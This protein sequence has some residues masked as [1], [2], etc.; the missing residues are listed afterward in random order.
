MLPQW[1]RIRLGFGSAED[2]DGHGTSVGGIIT[3]SG[4]ATA[5]G[6]A[7]DAGIVAIKVLRANGSGKFSDIAAVLDWL[8]GNHVSLGV[9]V[10]ILTLSDG[11]E[12][13]NPLASPCS[14]TNSSNAIRDLAAA[15]VTVFLASG[16]DGHDDGISFP[17][18]HPME[19]PSAAST[20]PTSDPLR[21][22]A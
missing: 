16:N 12:Y 20:T 18:V 22:A 11:G 17:S 15:G 5:P 7:P 3:A 9:S 6:V 10:I 2:D 8:I 1:Q 4:A 21:G 19:S 14:D 13:S